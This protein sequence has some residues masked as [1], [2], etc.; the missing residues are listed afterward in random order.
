MEF[1]RT[2]SLRCYQ[3]IGILSKP[4]NKYKRRKF[5]PLKLNR[6]LINAVGSWVGWGNLVQI[7][8]LIVALKDINSEIEITILVSKKNT[9]TIIK[10]FPYPV[11]LIEMSTDHEYRHFNYIRFALNFI[12]PQKYDMIIS[13]LLQSWFSIYSFSLFGGS[14]CTIGYANT[15]DSVF[16][17][18][19]TFILDNEEM[20]RVTTFAYNK[21]LGGI[22][23]YK[24]NWRGRLKTLDNEKI[25]I[26]TK[27]K[28]IVTEAGFTEYGDLIL[29]IHP[30]SGKLQSFKRWPAERFAEVASMFSTKH[31]SKILIFSGPDETDEGVIIED[32][33]G[34][35]K[36]ILLSNSDPIVTLNLVEQCDV[37]LSNDSALMNIAAALKIPT[38]GICCVGDAKRLEKIYPG[39]RFIQCSSGV[40]CKPCYGTENFLCCPSGKTGF[41]E[42]LNLLTVEQV[43]FELET[44]YSK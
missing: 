24:K 13:S 42:C 29:G 8:P 5:D 17:I 19:T 35:E 14:K 9:N 38:I 39:N 15:A 23:S 30:G 11:S 31:N 25:G 18:L 10:F 27:I 44:L 26:Q 16:N 32:K 33:I 1:V 36:S 22:L 4:L 40:N 12:R 34:K 7:T 6:V 2:I 43:Y 20:S 37:F 28:D 41:A 3:I 21:Q